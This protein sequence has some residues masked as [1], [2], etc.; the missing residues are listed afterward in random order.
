[1]SEPKVLHEWTDYLGRA[2]R[3]VDPWPERDCIK[4]L[5][6]QYCERGEWTTSMASA[7]PSREILRLL[8]ERDA[9]REA[10]RN[11]AAEASGALSLGLQH[12][13]GFTNAA[14][15]QVRVDEARAALRASEE[16]EGGR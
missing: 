2:N 6:H 7:I 3:I 9:L 11:L 8:S 4:P 15:L 13:I 10:L 5:R 1:M 16:R 14:V 12:T